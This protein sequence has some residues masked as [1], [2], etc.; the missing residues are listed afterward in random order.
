MFLDTATQKG[1]PPQKFGAIARGH[2]EGPGW[3]LVSVESDL[4]LNDARAAR[5]RFDQPFVI[6]HS[7]K[8]SLDIKSPF[9]VEKI[10]R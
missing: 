3:H 4:C 7:E 2:F 5:F 8:M 6:V 9:W 1:N 10:G